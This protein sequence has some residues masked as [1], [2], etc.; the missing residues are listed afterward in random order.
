LIKA[1]GEVFLEEAAIVITLAKIHILKIKD[2]K[3]IKKIN[4]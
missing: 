2:D 3:M 4:F 1:Y